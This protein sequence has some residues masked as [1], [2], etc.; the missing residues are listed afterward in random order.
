MPPE[1]EWRD[2]R[3]RVD[4]FGSPEVGKA[5]ELFDSEIA[6]FQ[7]AVNVYR[8]MSKQLAPHLAVVRQSDKRP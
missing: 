2:L 8:G 5:V 6:D 7:N 1:N 4:A 3:A